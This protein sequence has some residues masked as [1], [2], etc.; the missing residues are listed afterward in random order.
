M[1]DFEDSSVIKFLTKE[2]KQQKEIHK[3]LDVVY[4][5]DAPSYFKVKFW[6]KQ[7]K[8]GRELIEDVP[9]SGQPVEEHS[10]KMYQKV[11]III[12]EDRCV[13]KIVCCCSSTK[14][15]HTS[16]KRH[17][18]NH[19]PFSPDPPPSEIFL[20]RNMK[21]FPCAQPFPDNKAVKEAVI[22][23]KLTSGGKIEVSGAINGPNRVP[24]ANLAFVTTVVEPSAKSFTA[25]L[26][27]RVNRACVGGAAVAIGNLTARNAL[28]SDAH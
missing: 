27:G 6:A 13:K 7:F 10:K 26:A 11:E 25:K 1:R 16:C 19:P 3:R 4:G 12:F 23:G 2:E 24:L 8:R 15:L 17:A 22:G 5:E 14:C 9:H 28:F 21:T 20:F 18:V